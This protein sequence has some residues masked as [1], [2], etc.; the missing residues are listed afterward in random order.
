MDCHG[1]FG[2]GRL[3][4]DLAIDLLRREYLAG[5]L[6]EEFQN[7]V[8]QWGQGHRLIVDGD[9]SGIVVQRDAA[10]G[11]GLRGGRRQMQVTAEVAANTHQQLRL[12]KG[13]SDIIIGADGEPQDI[14]S[15]VS[16]GGQEDHRQIMHL[17]QPGDG[18]KTVQPRQLRA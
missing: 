2:G 11:E 10:D 6:H 4:P 12:L 9:G 15:A 7:V 5:M 13:L 17:P 16:P 18:G 14:F 3:P 1:V 8:L